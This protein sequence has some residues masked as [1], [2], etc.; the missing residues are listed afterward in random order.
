M[1]K[2]DNE[3]KLSSSNDELDKSM[4]EEVDEDLRDVPK[5]FKAYSI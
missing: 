1:S 3:S 5:H 2:G 4:D